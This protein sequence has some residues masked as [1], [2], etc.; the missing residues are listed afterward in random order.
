[1][2]C[3]VCTLQIK[4]QYMIVLIILYPVE[5]DNEPNYWLLFEIHT[6][7]LLL[8][9]LSNY[10][11]ITVLLPS[12]LIFYFAHFRLVHEIR[13]ILPLVI[14]ITF[15]AKKKKNYFAV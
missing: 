7:A 11:H 13:I 1:M 6:P 12:S 9:L 15:N 3:M 14:N 8:V 5:N 4:Y 2:M 10:N